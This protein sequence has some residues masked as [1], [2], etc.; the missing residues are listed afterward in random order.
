M[1]CCPWR[2]KSSRKGLPRL[3][4][5]S[6]SGFLNL[7]KPLQLTSHD[8]VAQ[9]RRHYRARTGFKKVGHAGAL[10]PLADGVL[11][12]C[13]GAATRLSDYVMRGRKIY[14]ARITLGISTTTYDAAGDI[15]E[16]RCAARIRRCDIERAL[17]SF[18][19][20]IKQTPPMY[21]A[22]KVGGKKLYELARQGRTIKREPRAITVHSIKLL[23]WR[24]PVLELEVECGAGTYIRSLAHDLGGVLGVGG[25]LSGLTRTASGAFK[26]SDSLPLEAIASGGEWLQRIIAPYEALTEYSRVTL[27][28]HDIED[29]RHGRCIRRQPGIADHIVFA[30]DETYQLVAILEPRADLWKPR[31]VFPG[32]S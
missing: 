2:V 20:D 15:L 18:I 27:E 3:T 21:S 16:R 7:N 25:Y 28:D 23:S 31:K 11:V 26:L 14:H 13:L 22:I 30:F 8:V 5:M 1:S 12:L 9:A 32:G 19:G 10:D 4:E 17:P 6:P 24:N 29:L